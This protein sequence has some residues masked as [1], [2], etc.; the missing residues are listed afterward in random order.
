MKA[1]VKI[2]LTIIGVIFMA[3]TNG[4]RPIPP[5]QIRRSIHQRFD[6]IDNLGVVN[7]G[8]YVR[9]GNGRKMENEW[10]MER[11]NNGNEYLTFEVNLKNRYGGTMKTFKIWS[12]PP[13]KMQIFRCNLTED[14]TCVPGSALQ[15]KPGTWLSVPEPLIC[16]ASNQ[17]QV[18][19]NETMKNEPSNRTK[20][21][22]T[23]AKCF[24]REA[25]NNKDPTPCGTGTNGELLSFQDLV[26]ESARYSETNSANE[27]DL[28]LARGDGIFNWDDP[29][30]SLNNM[31]ICKK[32]YKDLGR[33]WKSK[34]P[35]IIKKAIQ[36]GLKCM[37]PA[38]EGA[39]SH[40]DPAKAKRDVQISKEESEALLLIK[41][42]FVPLGTG[43]RSC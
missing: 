31:F 11:N 2:V 5:S 25:K 43:M 37:V 7:D 30:M 36:E 29:S 21:A 40:A 19:K 22:P 4:A 39:I 9:N 16:P 10:V 35:Y 42:I 14:D 8:K 12:D 33:S 28:I 38:I 23:N 27:A 34:R 24:M 15:W 41:K 3:V 6:C 1:V 32:H 13:C 17:S 26:Q 20:R 18:N